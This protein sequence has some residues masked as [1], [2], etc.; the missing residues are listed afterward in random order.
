[1]WFSGVPAGGAARAVGP[2]VIDR[3]SG[4]GIVLKMFA[5]CLAASER[6]SESFDGVRFNRLQGGDFDG[7]AIAVDGDHREVAAVGVSAC[8]TSDVDSIDA[9]ADLH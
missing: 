6:G 7:A 4:R 5:L 8:S 2:T 9:D 3:S 1:M